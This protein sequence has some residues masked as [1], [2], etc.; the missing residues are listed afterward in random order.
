MDRRRVRRDRARRACSRGSLPATFPIS[1]RLSAR[2]GRVPADLLERDGHRVRARRRCSTLHLTRAA[3]EPRVVRVAR[4]G[5]ARRW[6]AVTL[7]LTFSRGAIWVLPVGLVL[8]V[9]LAQPR[10][11]VSARRSRRSRPAIAVKVAYGAELL[12]RADYD[13]ARR[14]AAQARRVGFD[15]RSRAALAAAALR[16]PRCCWPTRGSS[17]SS[18]RRV[19]RLVFAAGVARRA[20]SSGALAVGAPRGS[21]TPV[22]TFTRGPVHRR[23]ERPARPA[24]LG[25][26]QRAHRQLAGRAGRRSTS[27]RCTAPAPARTGSPGTATARRRRSRSTTATRSTSRRCPSWASSASLLLA[28]RARHAPGRRRCCALRGPERHALRRVRRRG[29]D[30]RD[31]RRRSTGTGRCRRCSCGSSAPAGWRWRRARPRA[32]RARPH[33][34]DRRRARR[35]RAG[36]HARAVRLLAGPARR[37]RRRPSRAR[38]CATAID[39]A[40][41]ATERFGTRPEPWQILGYCDA[42]LGAATRSPGARWTPPAS[43]TRTTGSIAYGQAIVYGVSGRD[44]RPYARGGAAAEPARR[45]TPGGSC[46]GSARRSRGPASQPPTAT[47]PARAAEVTAAHGAADHRSYVQY[48]AGHSRYSA[49]ASRVRRRRTR[50]P[51]SSARPP[52]RTGIAAKPVNGSWLVWPGRDLALAGLAG[53]VSSAGRTPPPPVSSAGAWS[54]LVS[55]VLFSSAGRTPPSPQTSTAPTAAGGR[56][57]GRVHATGRRGR[58]RAD[59]RAVLRHRG[60]VARADAQG[61]RRRC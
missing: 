47:S 26:R 25:G 46:A 54:R 31:A 45:A 7:Y 38:D 24:D 28:D 43:A 40:L 11:L 59:G 20:A 27:S 22:D 52:S 51:A 9:L 13:T 61:P 6:S 30:A 55:G 29:D 12:A 35:A 53:W 14:G 3:R 60:V 57:L 8:Y 4:R 19:A 58:G 42:R 23:L 5:G 39:A 32:G 48:V 17:G 33:A 34:A 16:A 2:A 50:P 56:G 21:P 15:R 10:G 49:R 37:R 1:A 18:S 41:T 44:P 36:D